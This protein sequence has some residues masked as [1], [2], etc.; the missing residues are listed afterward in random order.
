LLDQKIH[1]AAGTLTHFQLNPDSPAGAAAQPLA[2]FSRN[3]GGKT[4]LLLN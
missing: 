2:G 1:F 3:E 4:P